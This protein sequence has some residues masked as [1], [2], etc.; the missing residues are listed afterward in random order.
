MAAPRNRLAQLLGLGMLTLALPACSTPLREAS[1]D[2]P[3]LPS[4]P[5]ARLLPP[6]ESPA[7]PPQMP[8]IEQVQCRTPEPELPGIPPPVPE[9]VP[10]QP[11]WDGL[12]K[13]EKEGKRPSVFWERLDR[14]IDLSLQDYRNYY[15]WPNLGLVALGLGAAAPLANTS[16]DRDIRR[17]YQD[18]YRGRARS[19]AEVFNYGGQVWVALPVGLEIAALCGKAPADYATDGGLFEWSHRSVRAIAVGFPPVVALYGVLGASRPDRDDS[20]WRPFNDIHGVSGH[21]F[22]GAVPFLTAASMT[23]NPWVKYPLVMGSFLTGWARF[24]EDRHYFSQVALG[25]WMAYLAVRTV[26]QT[27]RERRGWSLAPLVS[28]DCTGVG[29][30]VRY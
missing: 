3:Y 5:A 7:P 30:E 25:W 16:A 29:V 20:R 2:R 28:P 24:H 27:E 18:H 9:S 13:W 4:A 21:T 15:S 11:L 12:A 22:I 14:D 6:R 17:W 19:V 1:P 26:N 23:D 8:V 10:G